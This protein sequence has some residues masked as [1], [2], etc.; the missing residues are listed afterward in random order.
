MAVADLLHVTGTG[1]LFVTTI[2]LWIIVVEQAGPL[3]NLGRDASN[4]QAAQRLW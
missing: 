4:G 3:T 1:H 2:R